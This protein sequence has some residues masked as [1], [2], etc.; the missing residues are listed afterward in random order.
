M[1]KKND[2]ERNF[3]ECEGEREK[4]K[5]DQRCRN[6]QSR[7]EQTVGTI[8]KRQRENKRKKR[9]ENEENNE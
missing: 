3:E 5:M 1:K 8:T 2:W 7:S 4:K 6:D 9:G